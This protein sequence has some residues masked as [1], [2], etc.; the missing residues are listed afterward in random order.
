MF[1]KYRLLIFSHNPDKLMPFYRDVLKFKLREKVDIPNDY[2]YMLE[3]AGDLWLWIGKHSQIRGKNKDPYRHI[4]NL[5]PK[6]SVKSWYNKIKDI[7]GVKIICK[8]Q[9]TPFA[10]KKDP[11]YVCT[12]LDPEGNCWQ[13]MGQ[14]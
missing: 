5:Y 8:P 2:G 13:F 1:T 7:P 10:T 11:W 14:K 6:D 3:V 9:L 12:F 4:F